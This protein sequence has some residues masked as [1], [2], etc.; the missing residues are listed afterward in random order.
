MIDKHSSIQS[1]KYT[2]ESLSHLQFDSKADWILAV[3]G[4][5][6]KEF[7]GRFINIEIALA[8][9]I[10]QANTTKIKEM[11]DS[12]NAIIQFVEY[13]VLHHSKHCYGIMD[14]DY[15]QPRIKKEIL[16]YTIFTDGNSLETM[17]IKYYGVENFK[18]FIKQTFRN[19]RIEYKN[20]GAVQKALDYSFWIG[21]LRLKNDRENLWLDFSKL[22]K[23]SQ[24]YWNF[25][26]KSETEISFN[27]TAYLEK[28]L[29]KKPELLEEIKKID[30]EK[31]SE[32]KVWDLCQGH[33]VIDFIDAL[34][35]FG[36]G[37]KYDDKREEV[38]AW[39]YK[40]LKR[41]KEEYFSK[42]DIYKWLKKMEELWG[43]LSKSNP[44]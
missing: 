42:S 38:V 16:G 20:S 32:E 36:T 2:K 27:K 34:I 18:K 41:Y 40:F 5:T 43:Q 4:S 37:L 21:L 1:I 33:D 9:E 6:D 31:Y 8:G 28:L 23:G 30:E 3:E 7:Y 29:A 10:K 22:K 25:L 17:L 12:R 26:E 39:E 11:K 44:I 15:H 35:K 19:N 14:A 13:K 24:Y